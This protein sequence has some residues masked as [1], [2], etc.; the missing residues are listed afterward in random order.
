MGGVLGPTVHL[1][2]PV[3][4][5]G[6]F[7][8][9]STTTATTPAAAVE[10]DLERDLEPSE[11]CAN[12]NRGGVD[13]LDRP[14]PVPAVSIPTATATATGSRWVICPETPI[15]SMDAVE[16]TPE[17]WE[18]A[19]RRLRGGRRNYR[20]GLYEVSRSGEWTK[21]GELDA[22]DTVAVNKP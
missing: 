20:I 22:G 1:G 15:G 11:P 8:V 3:S 5:L 16:T 9:A 14:D 4:Q 19:A 6:L 21:R 17:T 13:P 12:L 7:G 10:R 18:A 2:A